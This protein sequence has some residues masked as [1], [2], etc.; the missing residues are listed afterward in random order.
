MTIFLAT[1]SSRKRHAGVT[2]RDSD[3]HM[4]TQCA[5]TWLAGGAA[6][7]VLALAPALS[8]EMSD[9]AAAIKGSR[10]ALAKWVETQQ[11]IAREKKDWQQG[12]EILDARIALVRSEIVT[13]EEALGALRQTASE[14]SQK[15]AEINREESLLR[16]AGAAVAAGIAGLEREVKALLPRLPEPLREKVQPLAA[17]MPADPD[18]TSISNAER[19]QNVV[20]ILNEVNRFNG[21]V[22]M[23]SEI[24]TLSSGQPSEVRTIYLGLAQ[25]YYLSPS[26]EA[27]TGRPAD[28]GWQW[29]AEEAIAPAVRQAVEILQTKAKPAFVPLP[30]RIQ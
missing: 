8:Q 15:R 2:G 13:A 7:C 18:D 26:G 4:R 5:S 12:K 3:I 14:G 28:A 20:G 24:R 30:V 1:D 27:G 16:E 29:E 6:L 22:T 25:A 19:L 23:V 9:P 10:E 17:R 11:I 21:E